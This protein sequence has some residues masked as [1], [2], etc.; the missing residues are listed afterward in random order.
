LEGNN[1]GDRGA[2]AIADMIKAPIKNTM[3]LRSVNINQCGLSKRG[4]ESLKQALFQRG[5]LARKLDLSH[6]NVK[7]ERNN[8]DN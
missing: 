8:I 1:I 2:K 3:C 6:V 4:I 5:E 7:I